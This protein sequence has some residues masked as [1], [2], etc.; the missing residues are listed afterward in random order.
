MKQ[1]INF[2]NFKYVDTSN[3]SP[4]QDILNYRTMINN[5]ISYESGDVIVDSTTIVQ[6]EDVHFAY[7][8]CTDNEFKLSIVTDDG[9]LALNTR[10][11][12]YNNPN[13]TIDLMLENP[14][15]DNI[16]ISRLNGKYNPNELSVY[17]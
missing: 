4:D 8:Y 9:L 3:L 14:N 15:D 17:Y 16:T 13:T 2:T 6:I 10:N 1:L 11:F 12:A 5:P 7:L